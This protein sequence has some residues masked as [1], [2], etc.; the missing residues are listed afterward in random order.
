MAERGE[1]RVGTAGYQYDH[2][3]GRFYP[4]DMP[5]R[6]WFAHYASEFDTVEINNTFYNLPEVETVDSW[7]EQ[8]PAGFRYALKYS[9][10]G[11]HLK[12]LKD[13]Q[14]HVE[15]FVERA[16]RLRAYLGPILVQ[17]PPHWGVDVGRLQAFLEAL[18]RSL[19]WVLELR[20][21]SWF[22]DAVYQLLREHGV[23]LCVHDL[24]GDHPRALTAD[25]TYWRFHG[26]VGEEKYAAHYSTQAL[27]ATAQCLRDYL[28]DGVDVFAYFNN[29]R[30][31]YAVENARELRRY[32]SE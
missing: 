15:V 5:K 27:R 11:S 18:P 12:H 28:Q 32:V 8:T 22:C 30:Q 9:R 17:L 4:R 23:A 24:F 7:R 16:Q 21:E 20:D 3:K 19:Q 29:D 14:Q 13:P 10:Y 25:F 1:L 31:A 26:P 2:W 6:A